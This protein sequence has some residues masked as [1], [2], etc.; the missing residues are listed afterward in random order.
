MCGKEQPLSDGLIH[1]AGLT[2]WKM[3]WTAASNQ[4]TS[5][6]AAPCVS[7]CLATAVMTTSDLLPKE[8][9]AVNPV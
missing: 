6:D 7:L 9:L 2:M 1:L 8:G 4:L 5:R 3:R